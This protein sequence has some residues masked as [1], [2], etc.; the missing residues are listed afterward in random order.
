MFTKPKSSRSWCA[1]PYHDSPIREVKNDGLPA[2]IGRSPTTIRTIGTLT[3]GDRKEGLKPLIPIVHR[4]EAVEQIRRMRGGAQSHLMRCSDGGYYV[5][6]FQNNPQ[7]LRILCNEL[8]GTQIAR[9]MNLPAPRP[10]LVSVSPA[11]V[12]HTKELVMERRHGRTPC[13]PGLCFGSRHAGDVGRTLSL[14]IRAAYDLI[15]ESEIPLVDNSDAFAGMLVFDQWTCNLDARQ[16][17]VVRDLKSY[18]FFVYM[19]D[20]GFCFGGTEWILH[21]CP[22]G[23]VYRQPSVYNSIR[24]F[25][26]FEPWLERVERIDIF[27]LAAIAHRVPRQWITG[28]CGSLEQLICTLDRRR[29][30]IREL[31]WLSLRASPGAFRNLS[32]SPYTMR[33]PLH[34]GTPS[35]T[36]PRIHRREPISFGRAALRGTE[37]NGKTL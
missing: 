24:S 34:E 21:D 36:E 30:R 3:S 13:Q 23:G 25:D 15:P 5:V 32:G 27:T 11:L 8:L 35:P 4:V 31:L 14:P 20:N 33:G 12:R 9:L 1:L 37:R 28:D 22:L 26:V 10:S 16:T 2:S 6:K 29:K 19:I 18:R 17:V 7:G